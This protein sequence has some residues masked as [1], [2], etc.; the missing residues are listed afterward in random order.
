MTQINDTGRRYCY[1]CGNWVSGPH[2]DCGNKPPETLLSGKVKAFL[3]EEEM[4]KIRE[5][6]RSELIALLMAEPKAR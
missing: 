2:L 6:I 4:A 3:D 5:V 1:D